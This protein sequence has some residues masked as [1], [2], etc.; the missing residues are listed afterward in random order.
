MKFKNL[1]LILLL[2]IFVI[3]GI[4]YIMHVCNY[5]INEL[6]TD[7][8]TGVI[9]KF[10][11]TTPPETENCFLNLTDF[12][13]CKNEGV[14]CNYTDNFLLLGNAP[15]EYHNTYTCDSI[16]RDYTGR[17]KDIDSK[18]LLLTY[19]CIGINPCQLRIWLNANNIENMFFQD[20]YN[21][22][23]PITSGSTN[24]NLI[25]TIRNNI[26][27]YLNNNVNCSLSNNVCIDTG[28]TT[29]GCMV[30]STAS[31]ASD[32]ESK[33]PIYACISQSPYIKD[34]NEKTIVWDHNRGQPISHYK[35][36][37]SLGIKDDDTDLCNPSHKMFIQVVLIFFKNNKKN[38][39][40]FITY[41][42]TNKSN[43][44]QC[45][46][47]CGNGNR[48]YG[49]TCGCLNKN[50]SYEN[51]NYN[52]ICKTGNSAKDYSILYYV[53]PF[54]E[55]GTT[56]LNKFTKELHFNSRTL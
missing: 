4:F 31:S 15:I 51:G 49:L 5:N 16:K 50:N 47:N 41:V 1:P 8:S 33:F 21:E 6:F 22:I 2:I 38:I 28:V 26:I 39:D 56:S 10:L 53:N 27:N 32:S 3:L 46:M 25:H 42:D 20:Y 30:G 13:K 44:L 12:N 23:Y 36:S 29:S 43:S 14:P 24:P 55:F 7:E 54:Y 19:K 11:D 45:N 48:E 37:C 40:K 52:S 9:M 35:Y 18:D 34:G 17:L